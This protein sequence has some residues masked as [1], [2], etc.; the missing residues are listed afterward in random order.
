MGIGSVTAEKKILKDYTC[1]S[2]WAGLRTADMKGIKENLS[3]RKWEVG[4][5]RY[6]EK[7]SFFLT[8][9]AQGEKTGEK[10]FSSLSYSFTQTELSKL[11]YFS[12]VNGIEEFG[13]LFNRG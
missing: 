5:H 4:C 2:G 1:F 13:C 10:T 9:I 7:P 6:D 11:A 12:A 3:V 8:D